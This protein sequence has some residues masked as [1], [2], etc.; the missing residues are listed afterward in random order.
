MLI[1]SR[2]PLS[3]RGRQLK[4]RTLKV[5]KSNSSIWSKKVNYPS[6]WVFRHTKFIS[7]LGFGLTL[8]L[9]C[10]PADCL[11]LLPISITN[12]ISNSCANH[13]TP[14]NSASLHSAHEGDR[15]VICVSVL[16][17]KYN[18]ILHTTA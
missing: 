5:R 9:L 12:P 13:N 1:V 4:I 7:G 15:N 17:S 6:L 2:C 14:P 16:L 10:R 11:S 18:E 8:F 3:K